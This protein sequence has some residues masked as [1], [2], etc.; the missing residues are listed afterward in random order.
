MDCCICYNNLTVCKSLR[1]FKCPRC[2]EAGFSHDKIACK[3]CIDKWTKTSTTCPYCRTDL[4]D[5][6]PVYIIPPPTKKDKHVVPIKYNQHVCCGGMMRTC[7]HLMNHLICMWVLF[8]SFVF[9]IGIIRCYGTCLH[10]DT[11]VVSG[12]LLSVMCM[13][14]CSSFFELH[15][16][17]DMVAFYNMIGF[18]GSGSCYIVLFVLPHNCIFQRPIYMVF[19]VLI[20][21]MLIICNIH[22][23]CRRVFSRD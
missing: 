19:L 17:D 7:Y 2:L 22:C 23:T 5:R 14:G 11:C 4:E 3:K 18:V 9:Y 12:L 8:G 6:V 21:P 16:N 20:C 15:R 13:S 1:N 10:T